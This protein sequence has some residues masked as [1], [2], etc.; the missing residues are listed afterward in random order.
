MNLFDLSGKRAIVVGSSGNLGPIW[1][2]TLIDAGALVTT[3]NPPAWDVTSRKSVM[4]FHQLYHHED[5]DTPDIIIYNA[6]LDSSPTTGQPT[7]FFDSFHH[8]MTVNTV[9]AANICEAFIPDMIA[10]GGGVIINIGS[11]MGSVGVDPAIYPP[12]FEKQAAYGCSKAALAQLSRSITTQCGRY[13]V[14]AV[15]ISF[16]GIDSPKWSDEFRSRYRSKIPMGRTPSRESLQQTLLYACCCEE[17]AGTEIV[18]DGG[19]LSW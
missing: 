12:S 8:M 10:N 9:G 1:I 13:G 4:G 19:Y 18:V 6:A 3:F 5:S 11:V 15:T 16:A 7:K 2:D 14:R 17:L